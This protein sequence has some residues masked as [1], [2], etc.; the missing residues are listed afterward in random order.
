MK[1]KKWPLLLLVLGAAILILGSVFKMMHWPFGRAVLGIGM[2]LEIIALAYLVVNYA[3]A[4]NS[5]THRPK[6]S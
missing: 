3:M 1:T 6:N 4:F 2:V 5:K